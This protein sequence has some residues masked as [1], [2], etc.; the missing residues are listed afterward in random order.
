MPSDGFGCARESAAAIPAEPSRPHLAC[1]PG[2]DR[3]RGRAAAS[4]PHRFSV[5]RGVT[6]RRPACCRSGLARRKMRPPS[7]ERRMHAADTVAASGIPDRRAPPHARR[8]VGRVPRTRTPPDRRSRP[9]PVAPNRRPTEHDHRPPHRYADPLSGT[10][11]R[12]RKDTRRH[13]PGAPRPRRRRCARRRAGG[14]GT[15]TENLAKDRTELRPP[16]GRT[17]LPPAADP[18]A[19]RTSVLTLPWSRT[20][21]RKI[22]HLLH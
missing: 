19:F 8:A 4:R 1:A 15:M 7:H 3:P 2:I 10:R 12:H 17:D 20:A 18:A 5:F 22:P 14:S 6:V 13:I 16:S 11:P 9:S 21:H